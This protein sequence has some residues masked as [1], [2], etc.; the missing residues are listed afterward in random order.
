V[1]RDLVETRLK[2]ADLPDREREVLTEA[3]SELEHG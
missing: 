2:E 3:L 1:S